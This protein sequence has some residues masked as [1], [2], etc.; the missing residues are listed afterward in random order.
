MAFAL[1][2]MTVW[3]ATTRATHGERAGQQIPGDSKTLERTEL[4]LSPASR[5]RTSRI[6][7]LALIH[8]NYKIHIKISQCGKCENRKLSRTTQESQRKSMWTGGFSSSAVRHSER[9]VMQMYRD[10][11]PWRGGVGVCVLV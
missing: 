9:A 1:G 10:Q 7:F 6:G 3:L 4:T 11:L 8:D 5:L 2:A